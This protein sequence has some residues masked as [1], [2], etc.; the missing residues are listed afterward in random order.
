MI[1]ETVLPRPLLNLFIPVF[2]KG[3]LSKLRV[4]DHS[5]QQRLKVKKV[6]VAV[7]IQHINSNST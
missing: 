6:H 5:H 3:V 1:Y 7:L 4:M 2:L